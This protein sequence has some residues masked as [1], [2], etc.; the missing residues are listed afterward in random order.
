MIDDILD[1]ISSEATLGK[2]PGLDIAE[3][4][5]SIVNMLW[6]K[7]GTTESKRLLTP[8]NPAEEPR[9]IEHSLATLQNGSV[10]REAKELATLYADRARAALEAAV[11]GTPDSNPEFVNAL[12]TIIEF[13]LERLR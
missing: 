7:T 5:P 9:Y 2:R 4:K 8:P 10:I 6:L 12:F 13:A 3:R 1:V 11:S